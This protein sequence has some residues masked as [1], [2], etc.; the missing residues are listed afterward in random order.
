M[1]SHTL[2]RYLK[3]CTAFLMVYV[4]GVSA[5]VY[6]TDV[7]ITRDKDGNPIFSDQPS[8]NAE[9]II[10]EDVQIIPKTHT[11]PSVLPGPETKVKELPKYNEITIV[12]PKNDESIRDNTGALSIQVSL[13]P[14]LRG[15]D[16]IAL[17]MDGDVVSEGR[18]LTFN[19]S[20]IDRGTHVFQAAVKSTN[21][22][23]V[24]E[25]DSVKVHLQRFAVTPTNP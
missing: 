1:A 11:Q 9:K 22:K 6:A 2:S 15:N 16:V 12:S 7:Y 5:S 17:Y 25:S 14:E 19:L 20:N 3:F 18:Q 23:K 10:I 4:I 8:S 13:S 24:I 21:G